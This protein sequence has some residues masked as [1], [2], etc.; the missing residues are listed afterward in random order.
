MGCDYYTGFN[1]T[2]TT[3]KRSISQGGSCDVANYVSEECQ[4]PEY[5][6]SAID[7]FH[8]SSM[9]YKHRLQEELNQ[10]TYHQIIFEKEEWNRPE[11][12]MACEALLEEGENLIQVIMNCFARE[13]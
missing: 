13:R 3:N 10:K 4:H 11:Y 1:I 7:D 12:K 9:K 2:I 6:S 5:C 8:I